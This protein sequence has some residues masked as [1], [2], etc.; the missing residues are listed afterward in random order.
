M[1]IWT[2]TTVHVH[3]YTGRPALTKRV[4]SFLLVSSNVPLVL[5][6]SAVIFAR[7]GWMNDAALGNATISW[8]DKMP[9]KIIGSITTPRRRP[10]LQSHFARNHTVSH[11]DAKWPVWMKHVTEFLSPA[12]LS[13]IF[14]VAG[15]YHLPSDFLCTTRGRVLSTIHPLRCVYYQHSHHTVPSSV[16]V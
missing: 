16:R 7:L 5:S 13:Y 6:F 10:L 2:T 14:D 11:A 4:H 3:V 8:C 15:I 1:R 12:V 9:T